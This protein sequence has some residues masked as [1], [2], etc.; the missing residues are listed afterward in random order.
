VNRSLPIAALSLLLVSGCDQN[1][2]GK[3]VTKRS[4][5]L[6]YATIHPLEFFVLRLAGDIVDCEVAMPYGEDP[7]HWIPDRATLAKLA[8]A[9]MVVLHGELES[10]QSK[11]GLPRSRQSIVCTG[12]E[13]HFIKI[14]NAITHTHG[15]K[16]HTHD[17]VDPFLWLDLSLAGKEA[18]VVARALKHL[19]PK[20]AKTIDANLDTL[21]R[22]LAKE[23]AAQ[24]AVAI[25]TKTICTTER[26]YDY[27]ALAASVKTVNLD[28]H[29]AKGIAAARASVAAQQSRLALCPS[30]PDA[31]LKKTLAG[32]GLTAVVFDPCF[33]VRAGQDFLEV[34]A[35][36]RTRLQKALQASGK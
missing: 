9:D 29:D 2:A 34:M 14:K 30:T 20:H 28:L 32:L 31:A 23:L 6:V 35:A 22:D 5:P 13:Q 8:A 4:R 11:V 3:S 12:F 15:N 26:L 21:Q 27:W 10:W 18:A 7:Q 1:A 17:G 24:I 25:P 36:N 33:T 19:L 16:A